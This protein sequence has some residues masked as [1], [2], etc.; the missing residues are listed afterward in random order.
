MSLSE[1]FAEGALGSTGAGL[2]GRVDGSAC[3]PCCCGV[4]KAPRGKGNCSGGSRSIEKV[5]SRRSDGMRGSI[6]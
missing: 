1:M 4:W 3:E 2:E 5:S 6:S